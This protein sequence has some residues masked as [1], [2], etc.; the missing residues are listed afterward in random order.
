MDPILL[1]LLIFAAVLIIVAVFVSLLV[2]FANKR[3]KRHMLCEYKNHKIEVLT[4]L[5][6]AKFLIDGKIVDEGKRYG[7]VSHYDFIHKIEDDTIRIFITRSH[8]NPEIKLY[9]ND[10]KQEIQY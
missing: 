7:Y 2:H 3:A 1:S 10:E 5:Y 9:I 6:S 4:T 8:W